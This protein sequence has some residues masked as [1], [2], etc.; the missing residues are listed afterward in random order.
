MRDSRP[1]SR[2]ST[3]RHRYTIRSPYAHHT[4]NI[5][6]AHHALILHHTIGPRS[7]TLHQ[8][9][10][11][12]PPP[13]LTQSPPPL[14]TQSPPPPLLPVGSCRRTLDHHLLG[15]HVTRLGPSPV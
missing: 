4:L 3:A 14:L 5:H 2:T 6:Q 10:T 8:H 13:L 1:P 7:G 15:G 9:L 11:L 12:S